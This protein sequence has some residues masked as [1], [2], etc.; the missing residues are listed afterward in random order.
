MKESELEDILNKIAN[1]A[2][3]INLGDIEK[4]TETSRINSQDLIN[5]AN[6][7][8]ANVPDTFNDYNKVV[9]SFET[10]RDKVENSTNNLKAFS[11]KNEN[12]QEDIKTVSYLLTY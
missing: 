12:I 7:I 3:K 6:Q 5:R 4:E 11:G 2:S 8:S 1:L 10:E 9:S